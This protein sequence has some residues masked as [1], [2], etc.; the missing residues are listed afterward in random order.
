MLLQRSPMSTHEAFITRG[1]E[2]AW[3]TANKGCHEKAA[4]TGIPD[5]KVL[6]K[7]GDDGGP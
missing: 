5:T 7:S 2:H 6:R 4:T 1:R 3:W